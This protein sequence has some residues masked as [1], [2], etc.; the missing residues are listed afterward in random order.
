MWS[1]EVELLD[2]S[3]R[4]LHKMHFL[5]DGLKSSL[6]DCCILVGRVGFAGH[7]LRAKIDP[8]ALPAL[9]QNAARLQQQLY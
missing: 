9:L 3:L 1:Q 5:V 8:L 7:A 6:W 4:C 2:G